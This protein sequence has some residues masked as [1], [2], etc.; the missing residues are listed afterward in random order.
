M[1][2][3]SPYR[4]VEA[5]PVEARDP[6]WRTAASALTLL[7]WS[8]LAGT[9]VSFLGDLGMKL[10]VEALRRDLLHDEW[11]LDP[12]WQTRE[13]VR[14]LLDLVGIGVLVALARKLHSS[15]AGVAVRVTLTTSL[16]LWCIEVFW[17]FYGTDSRVL[18]TLE[19][20]VGL[21]SVAALIIAL[22]ALRVL[23]AGVDTPRSTA[24]SWR[25]VELSSLGFVILWALL[26]LLF[27]V[28]PENVWSRRQIALIPWLLITERVISD[29]LV[30]LA[31]RSTQNAAKAAAMAA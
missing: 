8:R 13:C 5:P 22:R 25:A 9:V 3:R 28:V 31:A 20:F 15:G 29:V 10:A 11:A 21:G 12:I 23:A 24:K 26:S 16:V 30:L 17:D 1:I 2:S 19:H 14:K 6:A 27:E 4:G 18:S 7:F